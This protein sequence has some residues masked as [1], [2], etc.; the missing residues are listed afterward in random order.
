MAQTP[1]RAGPP[2]LPSSLQHMLTEPRPFPESRNRAF[3]F[4]VPEELRIGDDSHYTPS[5]ISIGP[6]HVATTSFNRADGQELKIQ[7]F[8]H[9]LDFSPPQ[10]E[11][12]VRSLYNFLLEKEP[13]A[14]ECYAEAVNL[15]SDDFVEML[16]IDGCFILALLVGNY[17][18]P[19]GRAGQLLLRNIQQDLL[20]L[21]NQLPFFILEDLFQFFVMNGLFQ[22]AG[23]RLRDGANVDFCTFVLEAFNAILPSNLHVLGRLPRHLLELVL[24]SLFPPMQDQNIEP[25]DIDVIEKRN[26]S[27]L[28]LY[29]IKSKVYDQ[30]HTLVD[31]KPPVGGLLKIPPLCIRRSTASLFKNLLALETCSGD[32]TESCF[33]S[34]LLLMNTLIDTDKDVERL[35]RAG[36]LRTTLKDKQ[37]L[38]S[39]LSGHRTY[40]MKCFK[41][42]CKYLQEYCNSGLARWRAKFHR[43][44]YGSR[45]HILNS[46]LL[47]ILAVTQTLFAI[48]SYKPQN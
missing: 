41:G 5:T 21:E 10:K 44:Y 2:P 36:V 26:I 43:Y 12:T 3:I 15:S 28:A 23:V 4:R 6:F 38:V 1:P 18:I 17:P 31:I 22:F 19:I 33:V 13:K 45:F 24:L 25:F 42:V 16:L 8:H 29:G 48:L 27:E 34:Y 30:A 14:R 20:L 35:I 37:A 11:I 7:A 9:L 39:L 47:F 46:I 32:F 40:N